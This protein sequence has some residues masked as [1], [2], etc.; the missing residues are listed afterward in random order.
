MYLSS[1]SVH[2]V[3]LIPYKYPICSK[4][5]S[6]T[7]HYFSAKYLEPSV[8]VIVN[9]SSSNPPQYQKQLCPKNAIST[10]LDLISLTGTKFSCIYVYISDY[11]LHYHIVLVNKS[12]IVYYRPL[13]N[14]GL[15]RTSNT[16]LITHH[17]SL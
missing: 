1:T 7:I 12:L 10:K 17:T 9:K 6:I 15:T 11:Y 16:V 3:G 14:L 4:C 5:F 8:P 13:G 2:K